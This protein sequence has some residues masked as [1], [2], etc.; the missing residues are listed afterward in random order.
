MK[1]IFLVTVLIFAAMVWFQEACPQAK[2]TYTEKGYF[3]VKMPAG[4]EKVEQIFGLSQE[5][6]KVYG[7]DFLGTGGSD[8]LPPRISVHFYAEG[9]IVHRTAEKYIKLHAES[10]FGVS[11]DGETYG[12]VKEGTVGGHRAKFF[13]RNTFEFI[14]PES[15]K[16]KKIPIYEKFAV[17]PAKN[18]FYVLS[19]YSPGGKSEANIKD[20]ESV[21]KSFKPMA[22]NTTVG[23]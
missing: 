23:N 13:D 11:L 17:V 2:T 7:A 18:G 4:W 5:E 19:L 15:I 10:V 12:P 22:A 6:K 3:T 20:Y 1:K 21:L 16:Q 14:P 8:G 9:N